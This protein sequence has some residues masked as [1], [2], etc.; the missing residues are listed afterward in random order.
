ME[1]AAVFHRTHRGRDTKECRAAAAPWPRARA[2]TREN[3]IGKV[4]DGQP[5]SASDRG[6]LSSGAC[7]QVKTTAMTQVRNS[8]ERRR[9]TSRATTICT[10]TGKTQQ[11]P[12]AWGG[13]AGGAVAT[14]WVDVTGPST[15]SR[16]AARWCLGAE[17]IQERSWETWP[18]STNGA[19]SREAGTGWPCAMAEIWA[20]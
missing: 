20:S 19:G 9:K 11:S 14:R 12:T 1:L 10:T 13:P 2:S 5:S 15:T 7:C 4:E 8:G 17:Q 6:E 3:D 18:A 16:A